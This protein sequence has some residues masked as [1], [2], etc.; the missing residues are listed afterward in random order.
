M[1]ATR[2]TVRRR[3]QELL[4]DTN[5]SERVVNTLKVEALI[6]HHI[7]LLAARTIRNTETNLSIATASGTFDYTIH[8]TLEA[9][10]VDQVYLNSTG[11]EL[12]YLTLAEIGVLYKQGT[13]GAAANA[14]PVHYTIFENEAQVPKIRLG[15]TPNATDAVDLVLS[16][17]PTLPTA[18]STSILF[19]DVL[20][21]GL[22]AA[23][24][25]DCIDMM[26]DA[27]LS[28]L[29]LSRGAGASFRA[30]V[31]VAV[32]EHNARLNRFGRRQ[33]RLP[34]PSGVVRGRKVA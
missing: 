30:Q 7:V 15:P 20:M 32:A 25:A 2:V 10:A 33:D 9:Q 26:D 23:V 16:V 22:E 5:P 14:T 29:K 12:R 6:N 34:N 21:R 24:A 17:M 3:I 13:T 18:D 19:P 1:A 11:T 31:E 27:S 8:A 4:G 28:A